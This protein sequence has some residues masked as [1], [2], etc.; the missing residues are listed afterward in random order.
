MDKY[1]TY[2]ELS[3]HYESVVDIDSE[4]RNPDMWQEYIVHEDM[5][6]AIEKICE[7]IKFE[8]PDKRRSFWIHG[9]YGT[10][11][12]YAAIVLKH[13]FEDKPEKIRAFLSRQ[14][15]LR[16]RERFMAI[17]EKGDFLVV[18]KSQTT[19]IKSGTQLM[20]AMEIAIRQRLKE[21]FGDQ[22]YYG[23]KSLID[24]AKKAV[25]DS[26][27]NWNDIFGNSPLGLDEDY[28]S[29]EEFKENVESENLTACNQVA[30]IFSEKG[31]AFLTVID[32]F[33]AWLADII[34]GNHLQE[35]GIVF[36]WDEFTTY[37]RDNPNDDVLQPLSEYCK[38]Q[39]FFMFLIVHKDPSVVSQIGEQTYERIMHRYHDLDFH[40]SPSAAK[41]LISNSI[42]IRAGMEDQWEHIRDQLMGS[43][44]KDLP[45]FDNLQMGDT[46]KELRG[47]CPIHPMT[48]ALLTIV[49]QNFGASQRTIFRFMKD[50][51]ESEQNVGFIYFINHFGPEEWRWLTPD[52][53]WDYFFTRESDVHNFSEEARS[54]YQHFD[55]KKGFISDDYTLH[56]FKA[57]MLLI[58]VMSSR[59]VSNLY[60]QA[61]RQQKIA[62]TKRTLEK[63]F[64]GVLETADLENILQNLEGIDLLRLE[65]MTNG[66]SRIQIPYTRSANVF[67][68]RIE[69]VRKKYTRYELFKKGGQFS[70]SIEDKIWSK[71]SASY[72]RMYIAACS[73]ETMSMNLRFREVETE[74]HKKPYKFGILAV[75][76][77]E[78]SQYAD[79]DLHNRIKALAAGDETGRLAV[80]LL[81]EPLTDIKLDDWY[82]AKT[83]S[84][85]A[86]E[87][88]KTGDQQR[89]EDEA[90]A[91]VEE[92]SAVASDSQI[93]AICGSDVYR[94]EYGA[95]TLS[96]MLEKHVIFGKIFT[97]APELIVQM[98]TAFKKI[99]A[100]TALA[101]VQKGTPKNQ[102]GSI[103]AGLRQA[104]VWDLSSLKDL[105]SASGNAGADA[106]AAIA[107]FIS[108]KFSLG[109]QIKLDELWQNL[110]QKPF[111]YF[112]SIAC[113]YLL[114]FVLRYYSNSD[115]T[116]NKGDNNTWQL[117][118]QNLA[119]MITD[120]CKGD[121]TNNY[122]SPGSEAWRK[123]KPYVQ[124]IFML[125][126]KEAVN[127]TEAKKYMA[128]QCID[129]AGVPFWS[130]KYLPDE[131]FGGM[132]AKAQAVKIIDLFCNFMIESRDQE[133]TMSN[134]TLMFKGNGAL[135]STLS[136]LYFNH[137][138]AYR[139]FG[140]FITEECGELKIL[141]SEI[142][143][144]D[145][146][147]FEA[148]HLL[149]QGEVSTWT[150]SQVREKLEEL[151]NEYRTVS[152]LDHAIGSTSKSISEIRTDIS[153][154]FSHMKVPGS[155]IEG[156][157][158]EWTP[159]LKA[160]H[161]IS[162]GE[163]SNKSMEARSSDTELM[164]AEAQ[165]VWDNVTSAKSVLKKYMDKHNN[166]CSD[167]ELDAIYD[168]LKTSQYSTPPAE[169][170]YQIARQ[171]DK[172]AYSRNKD[173]LQT[174][175]ENQS[176]CKTV[177]EWCNSKSVPVQW[178]VTDEEQRHI[179][180]L[181][182]VQSGTKVDDTA[183]SNAAQYFEHHTVA[184]LK[185]EAAIKNAFFAS[186]GE[187]YRTAFSKYATTLVG[188]LKTKGSLSS[189]VYSW[190]N[191]IG[192]IR[193][194]LDDFLREKE[195]ET[196]KNNVR[197]MAESELRE[198]VIELLDKNPDLYGAF[199]K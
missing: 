83:H 74:L 159:T 147:M 134:I 180:I 162:T 19:N 138:T 58:A 22:A 52:F 20:M 99:Q 101:G 102:V 105:V 25:N 18:W 33:K 75:S 36:I 53:L 117:T 6:N 173:R 69:T 119:D 16:Y 100:N 187:S 149:M 191:K 61:P 56:V 165:T 10:G 73:S 139:G 12:S 111:G 45:E 72:P 1:S 118:D 79:A 35:T 9:T 82:T 95:S 84:E 48:I 46:R 158:F 163:W 23:R 135:K 150:E 8:D 155:V 183:L 186:I 65:H 174:L 93:M 64:A 177:D 42:H 15:L 190:C 110:E 167:T 24:A 106:V 71:N 86:G 34:E 114:G 27:I 116:W 185:D 143:L 55:T 131:N 76:I 70:K 68:T 60:S 144:S 97:A 43:I 3:P 184:S 171:L 80:Y 199:M 51:S 157:G 129:K 47:L 142:G 113:G 32:D 126:D 136:E 146:N 121:V 188:R 91:I 96:D 14:I 37:L 141:Q 2:I 90:T 30:Q 85:L 50:P 49:A 92:W 77:A 193:K 161:S 124:K 104:G 179:G 197:T 29:L 103:A 182:S 44:S 140:I 145:N 26:A 54:A 120:M 151:C 11:K 89:Y 194:T 81:K 152:V 40:V 4:K 130:L 5:G 160:M 94:P 172:I 125:S 195:C 170:D 38:E 169:F 148:L 123:F 108:E 7:S 66:D 132:A 122:L 196:A 112:N 128:K 63:C 133:Q 39:P 181:H 178:V 127:E 137:D 88:G 87:E 28:G 189:N 17:R 13:L 164:K 153:N 154:A 115:F 156:L 166:V 98:S 57:A 109:V 175:W 62:P 107:R 198:K 59:N 176:G 78:T 168:A 21:K 31:W 192:E 67:D 41:E